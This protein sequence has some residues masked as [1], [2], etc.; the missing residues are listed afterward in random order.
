[1]NLA[2]IFKPVEQT[3]LAAWVREDNFA[4]PVLEAVH[5]AAVML[6]LGSICMMDLR[7]LGWSS[8]RLRVTQISREAL[9]WTWT[10]F[11]VAVVSGSLLMT[12]QAGA[13]A[14]NAQFQIKMALLAAAGVNM[15]VFH[16]FAWRQVGG[17]DLASATPPAARVA[18]ALSLA[19]WVGVV[20]AGR[21]VGWTVTASPF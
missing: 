4:F 6:V 21:W 16:G 3:G 20:V 18:G 13:Y 7:L 17:W 12:G 1:M 11:A 14:A 10:A 9:P 15:L 2:A 19:L 8:P 5:V